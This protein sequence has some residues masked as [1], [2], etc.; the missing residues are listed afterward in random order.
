MRSGDLIQQYEYLER[1]RFHGQR[2]I[3]R[4]STL[5]INVKRKADKETRKGVMN[6]KKEK[7]R[8]WERKAPAAATLCDR[9]GK[10]EKDD[11]PSLSNTGKRRRERLMSR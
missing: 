2:T 4:S 7:A 9:V 1:E 8:S 6:G 3:A 11:L 10:N 5:R